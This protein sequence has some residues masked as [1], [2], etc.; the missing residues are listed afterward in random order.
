MFRRFIDTVHGIQNKQYLN[1]SDK[2][3][4]VKHAIQALSVGNET[5]QANQW[6]VEFEKEAVAWEI[7][8]KLLKE[9]IDTPYRFFG[10]RIFYSKIQRQFYQLNNDSALITSLT[11]ILID[12]ILR[13]ATEK[14]LD[15]KVSRYVALAISALALQL[16]KEGIVNEILKW[17][18]PIISVAPRSILVL[19]IVLPE[20]CFNE[21]VDVSNNQRVSFAT[22]LTNS[23]S[24]V[25][26]FLSYLW[27]VGDTDLKLQI[28]QC[29]ENWIKYTRIP[30]DYLFSQPLFRQSLACLNG[31]DVFLETS[32]DF[33]ISVIHKYSVQNFDLVVSVLSEL[34][35]LKSK[36]TSKCQNLNDNLDEDDLNI[37]QSISRLFSEAAETYFDLM[38][39]DDINLFYY[40]N[41]IVQQ[42]LECARFQHDLNV[43]RIPL[44][45]F[46]ELSNY[47]KSAIV[48]V[49]ISHKYSPIF[50]TLSDISIQQMLLPEDVL[51]GRRKPSDDIEDRRHEWRDTYLDCNEVVGTGASLSRLCLH[52]K[53]EINRSQDEKSIRFNIIE[54]LLYCM[55]LIAGSIDRNENI[56][57]PNIVEFIVTLPASPTELRLTIIGLVGKLAPW[58]AGNSKFY[59]PLLSLIL[60][61]LPVPITGIAAARTVMEILKSCSRETSFPIQNLLRASIDARSSIVLSTTADCYIIEGICVSISNLKQDNYYN[62]FWLIVEPLLINLRSIIDSYQVSVHPD[63]KVVFSGYLDRLTVAFRHIRISENL[64]LDSFLQVFPVL[65]RVLGI[66]YTDSVCEKVCRFLKH[67]VRSCGNSFLPHLTTLAEYLSAQFQVHFSSSFVYVAS[68]CVSDYSKIDNGAYIGLIYSLIWDISNTFFQK[69]LSIDKYVE[70]PDVVEEYFYM[71]AKALRYCPEPFVLSSSSAKTI[72]QSG[73]SALALRHREAQKAVMLFFERLIQLSSPR[74]LNSSE[75][76]AMVSSLVHECGVHILRGVV[77]LLAGESEGKV[78]AIDEN[79]GCV[80]DVLWTLKIVL[81]EQSYVSR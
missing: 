21:Q 54:S 65:Q 62:I 66:C 44:K 74:A 69:L 5:K 33:A 57:L 77:K 6:L 29:F 32:V 46:Y 72:I 45:F 43:S 1:M 36:W 81:N 63:G 40:Q 12:H 59:E 19:L 8:D 73:I 51:Y 50:A 30:A 14:P 28:L 79:D 22:Q 78:Y 52:L 68:I 7:A 67:A 39:S 24:D 11:T 55:Y 76:Q 15:M 38:V 37:C 34:I 47:L 9:D 25:V 2:L 10:A 48:K 75:A 13:L 4:L 18:N 17:L 61:S 3:D 56:Y 41:E 58:I 20:E 60:E 35:L 64:V 26:S 42:L 23:S 53:L 16:N 80:V 27:T 70:Y 71:I 31:N 49:D